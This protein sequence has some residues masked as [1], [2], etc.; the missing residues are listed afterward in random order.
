M[1]LIDIFIVTAKITRTNPYIPVEVIINLKNVA[2]FLKDFNHS[3]WYSRFFHV[4]ILKFYCR[5]I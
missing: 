2:S 4:F 3:L 5:H 1:S